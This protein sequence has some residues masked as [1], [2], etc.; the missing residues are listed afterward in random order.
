MSELTPEEIT[1]VT[2]QFE[3]A[4]QAAFGVP[5]SLM[6]KTHARA[7]EEKLLRRL[8]LLHQEGFR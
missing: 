6:S 3:V 1:A 4:I 5:D 7:E 8:G 2:D